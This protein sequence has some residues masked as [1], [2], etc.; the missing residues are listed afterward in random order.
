MEELFR[1]VLASKK[2]MDIYI[3]SR[4]FY[5]EGKYLLTDEQYNKLHNK[6]K[7]VSPDNEY[8]NRTY[9]D[10][11]IPYDLLEHYGFSRPEQ[12]FTNF[13]VD[14]KKQSTDDIDTLIKVEQSKS[15]QPVETMSE[16]LSWFSGKEECEFIFS[17]KVD[18]INTKN[19]YQ[20]VSENE[21]VLA[22]SET[23]G[24]KGDPF[25]ISK[26]MKKIIPERFVCD[27]PNM[28]DN[29]F[30]RGEVYVEKNSL[31]H[32]RKVYN[33]LDGLK[34]PRSAGISFIRV[35]H[36]EE[37]YKFCHCKVFKTGYGETTSDS[38]DLAEALGYETV[39]YVVVKGCPKDTTK[40][41]LWL[42][43]I[44]SKFS[45]LAVREDIPADGVVCEVNQMKDFYTMGEKN[46]YFGG[47]IALKINQF[48]SD[49][50]TSK[51]LDLELKQQG[52]KFSCVALIEPVTVKSGVTVS[53]VNVF[54]LDIMIKNNI[55][56]NNTITFEYK[57]ESS[58]NLIYE[59]S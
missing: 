20:R 33:E 23:R 48:G 39:P 44:I 11:P 6:I 1:K 3:L 10:D 50:Y 28:P 35:E 52:E 7:Q 27:K 46:Q 22:R 51:I 56:P 8:V 47:N 15:I 38:I 21:W 17:L 12:E 14:D 19:L 13:F 59:K 30:V 5:S 24:R 29:F 55:L 40:L 42:T 57:S 26:N 4:Y 53:R 54:N 32:L 25:N 45:D 9:D 49:I 31:E 43:K 41:K 18:G 34:T 37:D 36:K 16:A 2:A 58:V